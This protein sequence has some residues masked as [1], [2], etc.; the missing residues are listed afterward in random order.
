M[1]LLSLIA[2]VFCLGSCAGA[3]GLSILWRPRLRS[4]RAQI[5]QLGEDNAALTTLLD[6]DPLTRCRSRRYFVKEVSRWLGAVA[7]NGLSLMIID[8]DHFKSINDSYGHGAGDSYLTAVGTAIS[9]HL[10]DRGIVAR[11]GGD[12]FWVALPEVDPKVA[13]KVAHDIAEALRKIVYDIAVQ[14][15]NQRVTRSASIGVTR[16]APGTDLTSAMTEA[17]TALYLA[18]AGGRNRSMLVDAAIRTKMASNLNRPTVEGVK[19]G[20]AADEFTYF[21]QPIFDIETRRAVGVEALIRW[22]REDGSVLL[23]ADFMSVVTSNYHLSVKPPVS[24]ANEVAN[25]FAAAPHPIFCAFNISTAFLQ[26]AVG[27]ETRWLDELLAG[28]APSRTV[29]EIVENAVIEDAAR[30]K[31]LLQAMREAGVRIALDDFG[32]GQSNLMR[33]R[34]LPVDIVKIDRSFVGTVPESSKNVSI[35]KALVAMSEDL[36]FE[37]IAEGVETEAQLERL[38]DLGIRNAQGFLLGAPAPLAEWRGSLLAPA[39]LTVAAAE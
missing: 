13:P 24:M 1:S 21:V 35:L 3:A 5:A 20:L 19:D 2:I 10:G 4:V 7:A 8:I 29:L 14:T 39:A 25:A 11:L 38:R 36:E 30:T 33:L 12:E 6:F 17:D 32:T 18:K 22:V 23:P 16:V 31:S 28:L 27:N 34:D 26:R 37:I 9:D 15:P